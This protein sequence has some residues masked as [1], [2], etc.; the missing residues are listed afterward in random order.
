VDHTIVHFEIPADDVA[1]LRAFY[2][3]LFGWKLEKMPGFTN[4]WSIE[5][6]PVDDQGMLVRPGANGGLMKRET[7]E[8]MPMTYIAV[9]SIDAYSQK[10]IALGGKITVSKQEIPGIG[11]WAFAQDPEGN[12]FGLFQRK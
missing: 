1:R 4:Y 10:V 12:P 7:P 11:W 9:E 6:V 3:K 8:Q 5:T 2:S